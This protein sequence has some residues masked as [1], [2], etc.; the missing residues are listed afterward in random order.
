MECAPELWQTPPKI[1]CTN[2]QVL[3]ENILYKLKRRIGHAVYGNNGC[4][5]NH[6]TKIRTYI[7]TYTH[8]YVCTYIPTHIH[9]TNAAQ[10]R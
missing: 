1:P 6:N 4:C 3:M 10:I 7:H 2:K 9:C 8:T 5:R